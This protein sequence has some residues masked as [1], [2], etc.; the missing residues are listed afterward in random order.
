MLA[1]TVAII[2]RGQCQKSQRNRSRFK[3]LLLLGI[4]A[5][6]VVA[7]YQRIFTHARAA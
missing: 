5:A 7:A 2:Y 3:L 4:F 6:P 1:L